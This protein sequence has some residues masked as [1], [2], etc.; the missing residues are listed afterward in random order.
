MSIERDRFNEIEEELLKEA[1]EDNS[2][3]PYG[4]G[5]VYA[6]MMRKASTMIEG[7]FSVNGRQAYMVPTASGTSSIQVALGG[8]QIPAGS[9]VIVTPITDPGTVTPIIFH[10]AIPVFADVSPTSG[11]VTPKTVEAVLTSRTKAVIAVHLT[12]SPVDVPGIV[13]M[14]AGLGRTDVKIIEDV[15]QGL[16]ASLDKVPLG[17]LGDAGCFSL[18]S[19]KHISVGEGGF[20]VLQ[21]ETD[22]HRSHNFS[23]KHRDRFNGSKIGGE[24]GQ[25]EGPGHSLR[26]SELQGAMLVGQI[27][28]LERIAEARNVF[29]KT[30]DAC[31]SATTNFTP[32]E[33]LNDAFPTFFGYMFTT[34]NE[35]DLDEKSDVIDKVKS[36]L[37]HLGISMGGSYNYQD[38]PI[39]QYPLF[40]N[41]NFSANTENIWPAELLAA[42]LYPEEISLGHYDYKKMSCANAESYLRRAFWVRLHEGYTPAHA[43]E[44][45]NTIIQVFQDKGV[46]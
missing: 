24:H 41:R 20:V 34:R 25:Y 37:A 1:M 27:P 33:H 28:K 10:N 6:P 42:T 17:M 29:G 39:Y 5:G 31:L 3:W 11:L 23:D 9:E 35:Y 2:L 15:A 13:K 38:I 40:Q 14:L 44:I 46:S 21:N 45:A 30:L 16:G 8:L 36:K 22:Y 4:R 32:Q 19:H 26:M 12:G 18:N 7:H 43:E